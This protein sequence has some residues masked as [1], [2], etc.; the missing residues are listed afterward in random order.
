MIDGWLKIIRTNLGLSSGRLLQ[1]FRDG[2]PHTKAEL[3]N[4]TGLARSTVSLRLDPLLALGV[5]GPM[6]D[7]TSTGGRPSARLHLKDDAFVVG[8]VSFGA[9]HAQASLADLSGKILV[10]IEAK[11]QISDG[12]EV[13]LRWM[14]SE[15]KYLLAGLG[16]QE[17]PPIGN[18]DWNSGARRAHN[19]TPR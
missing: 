7:A 12:P 17:G 16:I 10:S 2:E 5:I 11:R 3:A 13:C 9:T 15:L 6:T 4:L 18:R 14:T 8:A 19:R 1:F